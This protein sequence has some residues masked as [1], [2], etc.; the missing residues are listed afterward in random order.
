MAEQDIKSNVYAAKVED[1][2]RSRE[3]INLENKPFDY[4]AFLK[5]IKLPEPV[6]A[7]PITALVPE[8]QGELSAAI[9]EGLEKVEIK[10]A[11]SGKFNPADLFNNKISAA[12]RRSVL[13]MLSVNCNI[14]TMNKL[15]W[16][17][18]WNRRTMVLNRLIVTEQLLKK[19]EEPL[20]RTDVFGTL[21]RKVLKKQAAFSAIKLKQDEYIE[22]ANV[23]ETLQDVRIPKPSITEVKTKIQQPDLLDEYAAISE[24]FIGR[25]EELGTLH[26]FLTRNNK[27]KKPQARIDGIVITGIGGVGKSTL[28]AKF[29]SNVIAQNLA[30]VVIFDFDRPG[31]NAADPV[32]LAQEMSR[33]IGLQYSELKDAMSGIRKRAREN[34]NTYGLGKS[35]ISD[36]DS[37]GELA[38]SITYEIGNVLIRRPDPVPILLILDTVEEV[39]QNNETP[40]LLDFVSRLVSSFT[41]LPVK[42]IFSGR[43]YDQQLAGFTNISYIRNKPIEVNEFDDTIATQ[44]LLNR[45]LTKTMANKIIR[46]KLMP[47][48]PLELKL[49]ARLLEEG[50]VTFSALSKELMQAKGKKGSKALFT[51]IIYRRVLMRVKDKQVRNIAYPGLILR[52]ITPDIIMHVLKPALKLKQMNATTAITLANKLATLNWLA[53]TD[54]KGRIWHR[55]DL[56][57]SMLQLMLMQD[58]NTTRVIREAAITYFSRGLSNEDMAEHFYHQ[59]MNAQ[60]NDYL[61]N[62]SLPALGKAYSLISTDLVDLPPKAR[63][64]LNYAAG[65]PLHATDLFLLPR[66]YFNAAL[67]QVGR[68][69]VNDRK[70]LEV[71]KLIMD[72]PYNDT[73]IREKHTEELLDNWREEALFGAVEWEKLRYHYPNKDYFKQPSLISLLNAVFPYAITS[74]AEVNKTYIEHLIIQITKNKLP[75]GRVTQKANQMQVI[76]RLSVCLLILHYYKK[77]SWPSTKA[78][79]YIIE[80]AKIPD[81]TPIV[82]KSLCLLNM[83]WS[84]RPLD[85]YSPGTSLLRLDSQWLND[86]SRLLPKGQHTL[87]SNTQKLLQSEETYTLTARSFLSKLN[88]FSEGKKQWHEVQINLKK[89]DGRRLYDLFKGPDPIFRDSVRYALLDAFKTEKDY[90]V[91]ANLMQ[92]SIP[93]TLSDLNGPAIDVQLEDNRELALE[94]FIEIIDRCW[95]LDT[96]L[97]AACQAKPKAKKLADVRQA[98]DRWQ[99][100]LKKM[101]SKKRKL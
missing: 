11:L 40:I 54:S 89:M 44:F 95:N 70:F 32:W 94:P 35:S 34:R 58:E 3:K 99:L 29:T 18:N 28:L 100:V 101:M 63:A 74:P 86:I 2:L 60:K 21:L 90:E 91:L 68:Q 82:Q 83:I 81:P 69:L 7:A 33:Q 30:T 20:P 78:L 75:F 77:L 17:L 64:L 10:A 96:L 46:S 45:G 98:Y 55:K 25:M 12:S 13:S 79:L 6:S 4:E 80:L 57:R 62:K 49:L 56:R 9:V 59:L 61:S 50:K 24:G 71:T 41:L 52:Y 65:Q 73:E 92:Q 15:Q 22:L 38:T 42:I 93:F 72:L 1:M 23:L 51:G 76:S 97:K 43:L 5:E 19:L 26:K 48:R 16:Q 27:V 84:D 37:T 87:V 53:Y 47:L 66:P 14:E 85:A 88:S 8:A 36:V 67:D 39:A 31:I